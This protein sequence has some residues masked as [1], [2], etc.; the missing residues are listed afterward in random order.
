MKQVE[1]SILCLLVALHLV[2]GGRDGYGA[3]QEDH[4]AAQQAEDRSFHGSDGPQ[5]E[6]RRLQGDLVDELDLQEFKELV[7]EGIE[8]YIHYIFI[9]IIIYVYIYIYC[10]SK[11]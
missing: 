10:V 7:K 11:K 4:G 1:L 2:V 9:Y 3:E 8:V 5:R 6:G